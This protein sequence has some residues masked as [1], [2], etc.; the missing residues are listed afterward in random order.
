MLV[1]DGASF[2]ASRLFERRTA[3][4][5]CIAPL[6]AAVVDLAA[7]GGATDEQRDV[8]ALAISEALTNCALHAYSDERSP[9]PVTVEA[10]R[11]D[12]T[13]TVIVSDEGHGM[14]P[15][16]ASPGLGLGLSLIARVSERV[17]I[18]HR[19]PDPGVSVRMSFLLGA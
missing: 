6:R 18:E 12:G 3:L 7:G 19:L 1:S 17:D 15:R 13:L 5:E 8:V 11:E 9:G 14:R 2:G 16:V 4:P 10:W